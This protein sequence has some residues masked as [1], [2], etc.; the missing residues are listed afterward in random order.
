MGSMSHER[1]GDLDVLRSEP[2][3]AAVS[4]VR[5][6]AAALSVAVV[7]LALVVA[8]RLLPASASPSPQ[9]VPSTSFAA[10]AGAPTAAPVAPQRLALARGD[11]PAVGPPIA[12]SSDGSEYFD[13]IPT[14]VDG[15]RVL[16]V[17]DALLTPVGTTVLVGGWYLPPVCRGGTAGSA[18]CASAV[19]SD[20]PVDQ[21]GPGWLATDWLAV[22]SQSPGMGARVMSGRLEPDPACSISQAITCQ[23]RLV[24][25]NVVWTGSAPA[26]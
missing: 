20:V 23:P 18:A 25:T 15:E 9:A 14:R 17:R 6:R 4:N 19:L 7:L 10:T 12:R 21:Q 13:G 2:A 22:S 11:L 24:V 16:R 3:R 26:D 8:P 1:R 5:W